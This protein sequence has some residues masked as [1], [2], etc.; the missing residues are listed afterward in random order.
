MEPDVLLGTGK[1]IAGSYHGAEVEIF[2][3]PS[4]TNWKEFSSYPPNR[5]Q[6][7]YVQANVK[8]L[9]IPSECKGKS[10]VGKSSV[11]NKDNLKYLR[12]TKNQNVNT[13]G[14]PSILPSKRSREE[15]EDHDEDWTDDVYTRKELK[16]MK[17]SQLRDLCL[18]EHVDSYS[19]CIAL[20]D[21]FLIEE[22]ED[23]MIEKLHAYYKLMKWTRS[24]KLVFKT[25][26]KLDKYINILEVTYPL[27]H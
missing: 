16:K 23:R 2:G 3:H 21:L 9:S 20:I 7:P 13:N 1:V 17:K 11:I 4:I 27:L 10:A 14:E 26:E 19:I 8:F 22:S 18:K 15:Q 12:F 5:K 24:G 6:G 25:D